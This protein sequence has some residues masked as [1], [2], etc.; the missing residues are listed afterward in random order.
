MKSDWK[1]GPESFLLSWRQTAR[2]TVL[3]RTEPGYRE[4]ELAQAYGRIVELLRKRGAEI[5]LVATPVTAEYLKLYRGQ[6]RVED[7]SRYFEELA[8]KAN[9]RYVRTVNRL[10]GKDEKD[11]EEAGKCCPQ[12]GN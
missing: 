3:P 4:S 6:E 11:R 1:P 7:A 8:L 12:F 10:A 2:Y 5:C 9:A